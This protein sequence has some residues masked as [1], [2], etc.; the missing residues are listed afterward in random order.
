MEQ[1]ELRDWEHRCIQEEPPF[2]QAACPIHVDVRALTRFLAAGD[3]AGARAVLE[4]TMPLPGVL[5]LI[6]DHP[7]EA[8][9][10]RGDVEESIHIG[11]LERACALYTKAKGRL[12]PLPSRGKRVAVVG[13]GLSALTVAWDMGRKGYAV[14]LFSDEPGG[15][16]LDLPEERLPREALSTELERLKMLRVTLQPGLPLEAATLKRLAEEHDAVYVGFD[17]RTPPDAT[18]LG[19]ETEQ[20]GTPKLEPLSLATSMPGVFAGGV[21]PLGPLSPIGLAAQGRK[22]AVSMDRLVQVVS[23]TASREKEGPCAT[24]LFTSIEGV[25]RKPAVPTAE[26]AGYLPEEAAA[27]ASRCL[28]CECMECVKVCAYLERYKGYPRKYAREIY[29]NLSVIHGLR[30]ANKLIN[31]CSYCGLCE[32]VCPNDF[33]MADL[34]AQARAEMVKTKKMPLSA[35][36]FALRDLEFNTSEAASLLLDA[37]GT[38]E[39]GQLGTCAYLFF[40]GCQLSGASPDHVQRTLAHLR[41]KLAGGVG[42][43]LHCCGAPAKWAARQDLFDP[44]LA[45]VREAWEKL[46]KPKLILACPTC[47]ATFRDHLSDVPTIPLWEVLLETGLPEGAAALDKVHALHDPCTARDQPRFL[48]SVRELLT[49]L[50][51]PIEELAL[52]RERTLCCGYGGLM[53]AANPDMGREF[54]LRRAGQSERDY[55]AYCAMCRD[56]LSRGGKRVTH[57]LDLIFPESPDAVQPASSEPYVRKGPGTADRHENRARLKRA[58][59]AQAGKETPQMEPWETLELEMEPEVRLAVDQRRILTEDVKQTIHAAQASG[60]ALAQEGGN[61]LMASHRPA[62]V[63]YWVEYEPLGDNRFRVHRAWCHR[64]RVLGPKG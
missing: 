21:Q 5:G 14:S 22:A 20:D 7:C 30:Q 54:A 31:S 42:V 36:D 51:A 55:L 23:M 47:G 45:R 32:T 9:C 19:L 16:L 28:Q 63:T 29:N 44:Q 56:S 38:D 24:R 39:S 49:R 62:A 59:L 13:G 11:E 18:A 4:R 46:G 10:R 6:C 53:E 27:E 12:L 60:R 26:S 25:Q 50:A 33:F 58:L 43:M 61:R 41:E 15:T 48:D 34:C 3:M 8:S 1:Q 2:C 37:R 40:P 17:E 57:L 64:M 35:H 52:S